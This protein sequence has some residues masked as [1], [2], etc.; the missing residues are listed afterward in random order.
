MEYGCSLVNY[1]QIK[2]G[3]ILKIRRGDLR[4]KLSK[5]QTKIRD[6]ISD[7]QNLPS[8]SKMIHKLKVSL[9]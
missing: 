5:L 6:L 3:S 4:H 8:H 9:N 7:H 1:L 2:Q